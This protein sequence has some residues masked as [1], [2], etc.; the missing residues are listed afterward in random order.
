[1]TAISRES[2]FVYLLQCSDGSFYTG[3]TTDLSRRVR[4][5]NGEIVGGAN[6]TRARR[7]VIL[8]W[9]EACENRSVAQQREHTVRRSPRREKLR[10][11]SEAM[12]TSS[13]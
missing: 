5:H 10:L 4:Q 13:E 3:V 11:A 7:P 6:Y 2:W 8:A 9:H 12:M 1:M